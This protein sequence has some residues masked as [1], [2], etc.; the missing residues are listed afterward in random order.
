MKKNIYSEYI[1]GLVKLVENGRPDPLKEVIYARLTGE[2]G[3]VHGL[4]SPP[5]SRDEADENALFYAVY[6][7]F[8]ADRD[9]RASM[10]MRRVVI[11]LL[12]EAFSIRGNLQVID[13]LGQMAGYFQVKENI[14]LADQFRCQLWG[15]MDTKLGKPTQ[16]HSISD[17]MQLEYEEMQYAWRALDLWLTVTPTFPEDRDAQ[18]YESIVGLF[19]QGL[20]HF[21]KSELH[22]HL[23][24]LIFRCL[25]KIKPYYAAKCCFIKMC[26]LVE[27][28]DNDDATGLYRH[29]WLGFCRELG[30]LF[31]YDASPGK[32][33]W[34]D[35]KKGILANDDD[36]QNEK[37]KSVTVR[38]LHGIGMMP[39]EWK[40]SDMKDRI[41]NFPVSQRAMNQ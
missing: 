4:V 20:E 28:L 10:E 17:M 11:E 6:D 32:Q 15:F 5:L 27:N 8:V 30:V 26:R 3:A 23:L 21:Y 31:K 38:S 13:A 12:M 9:E 18:Y 16:R 2:K 7:K 25:V 35:F 14:K 37:E 19:D 1:A 36:L 40:K 22:F 24:M 39:D 33:W 41:I 34:E 29:G